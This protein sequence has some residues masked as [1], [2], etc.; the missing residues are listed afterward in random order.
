[1]GLNT[2]ISFH[3]KKI[4]CI[5]QMN[6]GRKSLNP[7]WTYSFNIHVLGTERFFPMRHALPPQKAFL[8]SFSF[9][10]LRFDD[11]WS[12][13]VLLLYL[14]RLLTSIAISQLSDVEYWFYSWVS[15]RF[16]KT[17]TQFLFCFWFFKGILIF[18]R[19]VIISESFGIDEEKQLSILVSIVSQRI[20]IPSTEKL[21][22][23]LYGKF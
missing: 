4:H 8:S 7:I 5:Q 13:G 9:G 18:C 15:T 2:A 3:R 23:N 22:V 20:D 12:T 6:Y 11:I 1:M 14:F 17:L 21:L 16:A 10:Y 19:F